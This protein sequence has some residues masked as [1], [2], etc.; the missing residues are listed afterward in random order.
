VAQGLANSL[1]IQT[2]QTNCGLPWVPSESSK[3]KFDEAMKW[4]E[5]AEKIYRELG[6]DTGVETS[7][8]IQGQIFAVK[9]LSKPH[10]SFRI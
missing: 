1:T 6:D 3:C 7:W 2:L 8:E 9:K 5:T 10:D 4:S